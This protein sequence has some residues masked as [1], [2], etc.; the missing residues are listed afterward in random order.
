MFKL[1]ITV[2][3]HQT[4]TVEVFTPGN[5]YKTYS[6]AEKAASGYRYAFKPDGVNAVI[7]CEAEILEVAHA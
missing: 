4:D 1:K 6:G 5:R 3:D 7:T 2:T